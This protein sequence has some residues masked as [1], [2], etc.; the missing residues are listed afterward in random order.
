[1]ILFNL[2]DLFRFIYRFI[3]VIMINKILHIV[4]IIQDIYEMK[5]KKRVNLEMLHI[6]R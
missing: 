5:N 2:F 4:V 3:I 1:M 6:H